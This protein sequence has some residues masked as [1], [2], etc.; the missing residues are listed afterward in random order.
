MHE[1][2][3]RCSKTIFFIDGG[4]NLLWGHENRMLFIQNQQPQIWFLFIY[5][6]DLLI[7]QMIILKN[8]QLI[9]FCLVFSLKNTSQIQ[10]SPLK[11]D[12]CQ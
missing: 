2:K 12:T 9:I 4:M 5:L 10:N 11:K 6:E 3:T 8:N 7:Y 1:L